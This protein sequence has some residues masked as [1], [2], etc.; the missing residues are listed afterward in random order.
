MT[1]DIEYFD[2][3]GTLLTLALSLLEKEKEELSLS[4]IAKKLDMSYFWLTKLTKGSIPNP[5]V[6]RIQHI[7]ESLTSKKVKLV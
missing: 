4:K 7:V 1:T 5:S 2:K 3:E 6:N